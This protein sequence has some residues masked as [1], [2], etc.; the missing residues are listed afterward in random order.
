[1]KTSSA[2]AKGRRLCASLRQA[3]LECAPE[4]QPDDIRITSSGACGEDLLL[5]PTARQVF[6]FAIECKNQEKINIWSALNQAETHAN[7]NGEYQFLMP[8]LAFTKNR[9]ETYVALK[10]KDFLYM[11]SAMRA[12]NKGSSK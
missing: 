12:L 8:L 7:V 10:L 11:A 4:L 9:S 6:P 1:M 3:L 5:S 2:K